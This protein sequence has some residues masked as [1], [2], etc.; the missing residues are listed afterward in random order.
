M[1][2]R[3]K[4]ITCFLILCGGAINLGAMDASLSP[5]VEK[6]KKEAEAK[7]YVFINNHDEIVTRAKKEFKLQVLSSHTPDTIRGMTDAFKKKY[8][9]IDIHVQEIPSTEYEHR[10]L[11][12]LKGGLARGWDSNRLHTDYY[13]EYLPYQK[14]FDILGMAGHGVLHI[15]VQMIDPNNRNIVAV[16]SN[17]SGLAYNK[18]LVSE[19][20]VPKTWKDFLKPE[21]KGKKFATDIRPLALALLV[22]AW[23]LEETMEFARKI[24]AQQ[25][26]W[27]RGYTRMLA[28]MVAGEYA[29]VLGPNFPSTM[30]HQR[31]DRTGSLGYL[32]PEP[33]PMRLTEAYGI[34]ETAE[35]PHTALLWLEFQASP[36]GQKI[37]DEYGPYEASYHSPD[38]EQ[39]KV[40]R[41]KK[42]SV[43]DWNHY[44]RL[45]EYLAKL[46][47][48]Y[49]FPKT[50]AR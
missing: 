42:L 34:L 6:A 4:T 8:P 18:N 11:L 24:A 38:S 26:I 1:F 41:R 33:V 46:V 22:P 7:G 17:I 49:G 2:T 20:E 16:G 44:L 32:L 39:W 9:F 35:H 48:A 13:K 45:P 50:Q 10:F 19:N 30:K 47:E 15:P 14:K 21:Y 23:G 27:G 29:I 12:E 31:T 40:T 43:V 37:L 25:P 5:S 28:S 3:F 36:E